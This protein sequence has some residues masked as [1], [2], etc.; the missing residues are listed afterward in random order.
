MYHRDS[1][2]HQRITLAL[3]SPRRSNITGVSTLNFE[4]T[5]FKRPQT[6]KSFVSMSSLIAPEISTVWM[7]QSKCYAIR[8]SNRQRSLLKAIR[9][10]H[11]VEHLGVSSPT[12]L[13]AALDQ[14]DLPTETGRFELVNKQE[15]PVE[16]F[17]TFRDQL[18]L[19]STNRLADLYDPIIEFKD[20]INHATGHDQLKRVFDGLF[21][22][23]KN[24]QFT[25]TAVSDEVGSGFVRWQMD[26]QFR[27]RL[28]SIEGV[29][30]VTFNN[31]GLVT[32]QTDYWDA[33]F[34]IYGEFPLLGLAMKGVRSV[35]AVKHPKP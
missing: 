4:L 6:N 7:A 19:A 28:R 20:P 17:A 15:T 1:K 12:D 33:S 34:P 31:Q 16:T 35:V 9:A 24:I 5:K 32:Q 30:Y 8:I 14:F 11:I 22:Q 2:Y 23:L 3:E 29:S 21:K 18:S 25:I 27:R 26:Y 10:Q 13:E